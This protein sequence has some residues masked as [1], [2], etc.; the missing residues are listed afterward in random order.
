MPEGEEEEVSP[1][2]AVTETTF[3]D[4]EPQ[5]AEQ[6]EE[7]TNCREQREGG[8]EILMYAPAPGTSVHLFILF[9]SPQLFQGKGISLN[10]ENILNAS[11]TGTQASKEH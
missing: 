6:E 4:Q 9:V 10:A 8:L 5:E 7:E 2:I 11:F 1:F 3:F